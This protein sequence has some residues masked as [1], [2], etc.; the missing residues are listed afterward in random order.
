[1][2]R[3]HLAAFMTEIKDMTLKSAALWVL[4][5]GASLPI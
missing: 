4:R 2:F 3:G 1:M 5:G